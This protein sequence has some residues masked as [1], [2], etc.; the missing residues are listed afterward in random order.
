MTFSHRLGKSRMPSAKKVL[1]CEARKS[2]T[3]FCTSSN[4]LYRTSDNSFCIFRNK[5]KSVGAMSGEYTGC[6]WTSHPKAI[7]VSLTGLST[8]G[9]ALSRRRCRRRRLTGV[10]SMIFSFRIIK[11]NPLFTVGHNFPQKRLSVLLLVKIQT[12][13]KTAI[14]I[15]LSQ[16]VWHPCCSFSNLS[17]C[18]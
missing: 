13:V 5:W 10:N 18:L 15:F 16:K 14:L 11:I 6:G 9:L 8:W 2:S 4:V 1:S 7:N 12:Y 17:H 3:Y